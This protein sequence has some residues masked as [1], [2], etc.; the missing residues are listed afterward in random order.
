M[1]KTREVSFYSDGLKLAATLYLPEDHVAGQPRPTAVL[2][3]GLRADRKV[4]LPAFAEEFVRAGYVALIPDYRGFGDSEG[5][6]HRLISRE[7]EEDII[8]AV[9]FLSL[10]PEVDR[11]R[12]GLF[13]ISYGGATAIGAAARDPRARCVVSVVTFGDGD[14]W[15]RNS[16]RLWEYFQLR[17]TVARDRER[18]VTTGASE[19]VDFS[20]ILLATPAEEALYKGQD[21][22]ALRITLP[23]ETADDIMSYRP[24]RVVHEIAPRPLLLVAGE[25][26]YLVGWEES[27]R[28]YEL[29][30]DPKELLILP[31]MSHYQV[32]SQ[33]FAPTIEAALR[34]FREALG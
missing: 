17:E 11:N 16:R 7:R 4:F 5:P 10:Q 12:I 32:Y 21:L 28:L 8:N 29:A 27:C 13:G 25:Q 30:R 9:T 31:G 23:L 15:T 22:K 33:G 26:D 3:H 19:Y 14:R 20:E 2:C 6:R 24:E 34:T 18:R 1:A